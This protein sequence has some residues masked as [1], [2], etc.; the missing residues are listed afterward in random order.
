MNGQVSWFIEATFP[1]RPADSERATVADDVGAAVGDRSQFR[2]AERAPQ[3]RS[4]R[5]R[6]CSRPSRRVNRGSKGKHATRYWKC[7][8]S[9]ERSAIGATCA[10]KSAVGSVLTSF[11]TTEFGRTSVSVLLRGP[12]SLKVRQKHWVTSCSSGDN[13]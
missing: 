5:G 4:F 6:E 11:T 2:R 1:A 8:R 7:R 12:D 10:V 9:S 3:E 13:A